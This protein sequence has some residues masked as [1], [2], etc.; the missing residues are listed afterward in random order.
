[1]RQ[2]LPPVVGGP[3]EVENE[4]MAL[5]GSQRGVKALRSEPIGLPCLP[6]L[7]CWVPRSGGWEVGR[8]KH[9]RAELHS[10]CWARM[11]LPGGHVSFSVFIKEVFLESSDNSVYRYQETAK[12]P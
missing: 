8:S 1:M 5:P 10:L 11:S 2:V 6:W 7:H 4:D 12:M 3:P 9:W